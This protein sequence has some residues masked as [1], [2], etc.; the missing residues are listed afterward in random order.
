MG[1]DSQSRPA[2]S[3]HILLFRR[4]YP[5]DCECL[6]SWGEGVMH[7]ASDWLQLCLQLGQNQA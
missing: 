6:L 4:L 2:C 3:P 7:V 5:L 1:G